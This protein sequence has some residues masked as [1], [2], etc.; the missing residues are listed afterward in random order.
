MQQTTESLRGW[1]RLVEPIYAEL[2]NA[3]HAMC[4]NYELAEYAL[5][6]ALLDVWLQ[7]AGMG[8]R[9]RLRGALREEAFAA[10]DAP[11]AASAEFTWQG[12]RIGDG[13][14]P[15]LNQL[16][17]ESL[18]LQRLIML[19]YGCGLTART[20]AQ[21]TGLSPKA[22]RGSLARFL[23]RCRRKLPGGDRAGTEALITQRARAALRRSDEAPPIAQAFR[24]FETEASQVSRSGRGIGRAF[25]RLMLTLLALV[26]AAAFWL[27]AVLV[28]PVPSAYQATVAAQTEAPAPA[29]QNIP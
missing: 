27:F 21:L 25:S 20:I 13:T 16:A 24:A 29:L 10:L 17:G 15:L 23:A 2:F 8:F 22:V 14:D 3:A 1:F 26:C 19:R 11:E 18:E 4:G 9:E 6:C 28:R 5:Q 12:F 7:R